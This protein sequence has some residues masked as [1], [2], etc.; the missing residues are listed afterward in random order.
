MVVSWIL[1]PLTF[2][3]FSIDL[4]TWYKQDNTLVASD[5]VNDSARNGA[6]VKDA[7]ED[8]VPTEYIA[9]LAITP[10]K[11]DSSVV[12]DV[13]IEKGDTVSYWNG[14]D[15]TMN[16]IL[17]TNY[18][19]T[20]G[21]TGSL[22]TNWSVVNGEL[23]YS[24]TGS[25]SPWTTPPTTPFGGHSSDVVIW[26][27]S[28][29][30]IVGGNWQLSTGSVPMTAV[31]TDIFV[32][33][34][35]L[36]TVTIPV[37][38]TFYGVTRSSSG[39][40]SWRWYTEDPRGGA[41]QVKDD[42]ITEPKLDLSY[43]ELNETTAPTPVSNTVQMYPTTDKLMNIQDDAGNQIKLGVEQKVSTPATFPVATGLPSQWAYDGVYVWLC[44]SIDTWV[45]FAVITS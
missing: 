32:T 38:D 40:F 30:D 36:Y 27:Y 20:V 19:F 37:G 39:P 41:L 14:S 25:S 34:D 7:L 21:N 23:V 9:D 22:F 17:L 11:L 3:I 4:L 31:A 6:T 42:G 1:K 16:Q 2:L 29:G 26:V 28:T 8:P 15:T 18:G 5:I 44:V 24:T 45:K 10:I 35:R 12:D 33:N 43:L 13:T